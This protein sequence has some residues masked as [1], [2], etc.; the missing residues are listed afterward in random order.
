MRPS[1]EALLAS[2]E[3]QRAIETYGINLAALNSELGRNTG[4]I[5]SMKDSEQSSQFAKTKAS[6]LLKTIQL[7]KNLSSLTDRLPKSQYIDNPSIAARDSVDEMID[8]MQ[9]NKK[10]ML[11]MGPPKS[12]TP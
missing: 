11:S 9:A 5:G 6:D 12:L 4:I 8:L 7:P 3:V 2:R 1:C 10:A